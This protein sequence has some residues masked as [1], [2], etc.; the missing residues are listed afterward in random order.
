MFSVGL[1]CTADQVGMRNW[2]RRGATEEAGGI[3]GRPVRGCG[4]EE[5][6]RLGTGAAGS[7]EV[8]YWAE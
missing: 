3:G 6:E 8:G 2:S 1:E 5:S 7:R 4:V